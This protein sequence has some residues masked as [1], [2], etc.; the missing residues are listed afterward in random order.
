MSTVSKE[1]E[2]STVT[3]APDVVAGSTATTTSQPGE[4]GSTVSQSGT[5][6]SGV[7]DS[8]LSKSGKSSGRPKRITMAGMIY[9]ANEVLKWAMDP[10]MGGLH[11]ALFGPALKGIAFIEIVE[12]GFIF[13]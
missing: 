4:G 8:T 7:A 10:K 3:A 2:G 5:T 6:T 11:P 9:H 13:R 1:V 12:V